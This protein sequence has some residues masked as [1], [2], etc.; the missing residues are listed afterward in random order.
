[1]DSSAVIH[2]RAVE[3][4]RE[5]F[6]E[7]KP[8]VLYLN[9]S[10]PFPLLGKGQVDRCQLENYL[11]RSLGEG[12]NLIT[13]R[14]VMEPVTAKS[15]APSLARRTPGLFVDDAVR[16]AITVLLIAHA[17]L[18]VAEV[19]LLN[20]VVRRQPSLCLKSAGNKQAVLV[21]PPP[22]CPV[23]TIDDEELIQDFPRC[24]WANEFDTGELFDSSVIA[25]LLGRVREIA[26]LGVDE[27]R[28]LVEP[29]RCLW[30]SPITFD[31]VAEGYRAAAP[32]GAY[33]PEDDAS[34]HYHFWSH[35]RAVTAFALRGHVAPAEV[36]R[37]MAQSCLELAFLLLRTQREVGTT[38]IR[39]DLALARAYAGSALVL[40]MD[41]RADDYRQIAGTYTLRG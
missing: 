15:Q 22:G 5:Y 10:H 26:R 4:I 16:D 13:I 30:R 23:A 14:D 24:L 31:G 8:F 38:V 41:G 20:E 7:G 29:A 1:M 34:W 33:R 35:F 28:D 2:A 12:V 40:A 11:T 3:V 18:I 6:E 17:D 21:L 25:D 32:P 37:P 9:D 19:Y 27:R 39:G 36:A